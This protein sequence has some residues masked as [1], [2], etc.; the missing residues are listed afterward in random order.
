MKSANSSTDKKIT[1]QEIEKSLRTG[2]APARMV[3]ANKIE[4]ALVTATTEK[5]LFEEIGRAGVIVTYSK[6]GAPLFTYSDMTFSKT[7][8]GYPQGFFRNDKNADK[9]KQD[10]IRSDENR[11]A[12]KA[13]PGAAQTS[14]NPG[15]R[16]SFPYPRPPADRDYAMDNAVDAVESGWTKKAG[17]DCKISVTSRPTT[18]PPT[19]RLVRDLRAWRSKKTGWTWFYTNTGLP[20]SI[21]LDKEKTAVCTKSEF[22]TREKAVEML[23]IALNEFNPPLAIHGDRQ[24]MKVMRETAKELGIEIETKK[25]AEQERETET[26]TEVQRNRPRIRA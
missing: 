17:T 23:E 16:S 18:P 1:R 10:E 22:L 5:E 15:N 3:I 21:Y 6:N 8:L 2:E 9:A 7:K 13:N 12:R 11:E 26:E 20:T 24:F 25:E 14:Q 4:A 19:R